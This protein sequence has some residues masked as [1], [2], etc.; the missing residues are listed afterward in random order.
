MV[1]G[2]I[3]MGRLAAIVREALADLIDS[4]DI[5]VVLSDDGQEIDVFGDEWTVHLEGWPSSPSAFAA[6][7]D[8]P[9]DPAD[10]PAARAGIFDGPVHAALQDLDRRLDGTLRT[11]LVASGDPLSMDLATA[12]ERSAP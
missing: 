4:G 1:G 12:L 2:E 11:A 7:D 3:S 6:I 5:D 8:E 9:D 10:I